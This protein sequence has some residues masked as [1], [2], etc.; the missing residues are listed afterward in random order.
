[1]EC[2]SSLLFLPCSQPYGGKFLKAVSL[3]IFTSPWWGSWCW[4]SIYK[5]VKL[6]ISAVLRFSLLY[7]P[8]LSLL[9]I[10]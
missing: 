4:G 9:A 2:Q 5:C 7:E 10:H 1:M 6:S 3:G 8:M